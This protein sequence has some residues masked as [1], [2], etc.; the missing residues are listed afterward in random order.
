M[1]TYPAGNPGAHPLD[2][3]TPVGQFR[4]LLGDTESTP[5]DPP[6]PGIQ[7]YGKFSDAEIEAYLIQGGDS[8]PRA[9]GF[10]YLYLAG[11]AALESKSI[12]DYDLQIDSTK[13]AGD[14]REIAR[15]WF[16]IADQDDANSG[17][18]DIFEVFDMAGRR[19][20]HELAECPTCYG[21]VW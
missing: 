15:Y 5:Y 13:R 8:I 1:A 3:A 2:P 17:L 12:K 18:N 21:S 19:C 20:R 14:L 9:I 16:D 10:S 11:Q 7:D 4:L 6:V